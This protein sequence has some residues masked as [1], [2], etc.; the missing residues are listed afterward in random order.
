MVITD[1][2]LIKR[3]GSVRKLIFL[4]L[5]IVIFGCTAKP[6]SI[7]PIDKIEVGMSVMAVVELMDIPEKMQTSRDEKDEVWQYC[8]AERFKPVNSVVAVWFYKRKVTGIDI[9]K[10][11]GLGACSIYYRTFDWKDAP[12]RKN[13]K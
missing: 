5:L 13:A 7:R 11:P 10:N 12:H 6:Q 1:N 9:Y 8:L 3:T 2:H 4:S